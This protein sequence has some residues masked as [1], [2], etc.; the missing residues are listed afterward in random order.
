MTRDGKCRNPLHARVR[1][2]GRLAANGRANLNGVP[3]AGSSPVAPAPVCRP[4]RGVDRTQSK[5]RGQVLQLGLHGLG[6]VPGE[7]HVLV[8]GIHSQ[9]RCLAVGGG[10]DLPDQPVAVKYRESEVAPAALGR[11][12]YISRV[13]SN[14][15][16]SRART[17]SYTS[18]SK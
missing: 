8:D 6:H 2:Q 4:L 17:R 3:D 7:L 16:S 15:N 18:R 10:V 14:S 11:G 5:S 12:L 13:Y 9:C 1:V